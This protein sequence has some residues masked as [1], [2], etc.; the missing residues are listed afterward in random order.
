MI[1][2]FMGLRKTFFRGQRRNFAYS[3]QGADDAIQMDL[4]KTLYPF[5]PI[6]LCYLNLSSQSFV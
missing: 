2:L 1:L 5:Y 4:H 3:F 6:S